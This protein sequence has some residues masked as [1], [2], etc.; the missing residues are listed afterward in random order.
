MRIWL[1]PD[2]LQSVGLTAADVV[3]ALQGQNVQVAS[4]VLDQPP[5]DKPGAF[6]I[7]V[8]T[9]GRLA[10]PDEFGQIVVKQTANAIVR[11]KDIARVELAAQDYSTNSYLDRDPAI[12]IGIF[13]RPG[14]N[15]LS[16]ARAIENTMEDLSK[17]FPPGL[18]YT[19]VYNPTQFIQQSVDAVE[20]TIGEAIILVVL[21]VILFLQTWRAAIIPIVAIPVSLIGTF[22]VMSLF[23][24][25]LNNLSLF[26][27]VLAIGIVVDDAI[28]VVE[29]VER[30]IEAGLQSARCGE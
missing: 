27:L 13:Q 19:I 12:A 23:G 16:T 5:M 9:Q 28:V 6:Q 10:D 14:S 21:V 18:K 26:G 7:S 4:G 20:S 2:R 25:T 17:R 15:A 1:D 11:I 22:F 3:T 30:N 29:N 24:F 8:Q